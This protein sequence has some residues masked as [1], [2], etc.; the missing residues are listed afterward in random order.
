MVA[1][2]AGLRD[3]KQEPILPEVK[4]WDAPAAFLAFG[5]Q[6]WPV[7]NVTQVHY[8]AVWD[9]PPS[10]LVIAPLHWWASSSISL[11]SVVPGTTHRPHHT[12]PPCTQRC[13]ASAPRSTHQQ[14]SHS[15]LPRGKIAVRISSCRHAFYVS[16][17]LMQGSHIRIL[18]F[19]CS[20]DS[21]AATHSEGNAWP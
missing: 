4:I 17:F 11:Q 21:L 19:R 8:L 2:N 13:K 16:T 7:E 12:A 10:N 1:W 3:W 20:V 6:M 9:R 14:A 5:D 18:P 15:G